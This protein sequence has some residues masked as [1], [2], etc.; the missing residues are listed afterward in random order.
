M[1]I[2]P[3]ETNLPVDACKIVF[4]HSAEAVEDAG[5]MQRDFRLVI[6]R[7]DSTTP[8]TSG[9][10]GGRAQLRTQIFL[11]IFL[12]YK[13]PRL[14]TPEGAGGLNLSFCVSPTSPRFLG[15]EAWHFTSTVS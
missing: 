13:I 5:I 14:S 12:H 11:L 6:P 2:P 7:E 9:F 8:G 15:A 1:P 4:S 10:V 3:G